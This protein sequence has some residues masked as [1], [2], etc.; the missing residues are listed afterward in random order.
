VQIKL[1][2]WTLNL[3][4]LKNNV[5]DVII[6]EVNKDRESFRSISMIPGL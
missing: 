3:I 2:F 6:Y 1:K 5:I 4:L